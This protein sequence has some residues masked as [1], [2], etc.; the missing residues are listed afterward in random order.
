MKKK[1]I[2]VLQKKNQTK[3]L[4]SESTRIHF[5]WPESDP[6]PLFP[7][8]YPWI[9]VKMKWILNTA[10]KCLHLMFYSSCSLHFTINIKA[11]LWPAFLEMPREEHKPV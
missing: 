4:E 10:L 6:I 8:V 3:K 11:V 5:I 7:E 2:I 9:Q 1:T